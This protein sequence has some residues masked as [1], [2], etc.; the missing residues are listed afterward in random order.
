[1]KSAHT[2]LSYIGNAHNIG[3][4]T[5]C[6]HSCSGT[7]SFNHHWE[8]IV[9]FSCDEYDIITTLQVIEWVH[10]VHFMKTYFAFS[11]FHGCYKSPTFTLSCKGLTLLLEISI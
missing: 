10:A 5:G 6:R 9:T 11:V 3:E 2:I 4:N 1:M 7:I 8:L